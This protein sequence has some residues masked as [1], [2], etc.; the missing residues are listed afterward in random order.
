MGGMVLCNNFLIGLLSGSL[1]P[2]FFA[3]AVFSEGSFPADNETVPGLSTTY[4]LPPITIW[5]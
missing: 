3:T 1:P 4:P 5:Y 2:G